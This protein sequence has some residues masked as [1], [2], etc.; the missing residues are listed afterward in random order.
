MRTAII[1][2]ATMLLVG[3]TATAELVDGWNLECVPP[4][5]VITPYPSNYAI[6]Y[7]PTQ[8][9][10]LTGV[11]VWAG[12]SDFL[13]PDEIT[14]QI[15]TD[16]ESQPSGEVLGA[17]TVE[18]PQGPP[19]WLGSDFVEPIPIEAGE[20]YWLVYFAMPWA[21][22]PWCDEGDLYETWFSGDQVHWDYQGESAWKAKFWGV[23]GTPVQAVTWGK[24]KQLF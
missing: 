13:N 14:V 6:K 2:S 10:S 11:D 9:Y 1:L 7:E 4:S 20:V 8:T 23:G 3:S 15:Q 17:F 18:I 12:P 16:F 21:S 19:D 24:L 22:L 5:G